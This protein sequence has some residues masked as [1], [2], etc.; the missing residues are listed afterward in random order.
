MCQE[1]NKELEDY[2]QRL[3]DIE[4]L[5][6]NIKF[7]SLEDREKAKFFHLRRIAN[8]EK[9]MVPVNF[10]GPLKLITHFIPLEYISS[11]KYIDL[12]YYKNNPNKL[13]RSGSNYWRARP[14]FDGFLGFYYL[15]NNCPLYIQLYRNGIIE[16]VEDET[17]LNKKSKLIFLNEIEEKLS[18]KVE[19]YLTIEDK[20]DV[21]PSFIFYITLIG[22]KGRVIQRISGTPPKKN[23]PR[24]EKNTLDLPE[25]EIDNFD[26]EPGKL[27]K[28]SFDLLWNT[29]GEDGSP[30]YNKNGNWK[31]PN[32]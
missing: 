21:K 18:Q 17:P 29:G 31:K 11:N 3:V 30:N 7:N 27:L 19:F 24:I 28:S 14:N 23:Y 16:E 25:I 1:E 8:L 5:K 12:S 22:V 26:I 2:V 15:N 6:L 4:E 32:K 13:S 20:L 10:E 9:N